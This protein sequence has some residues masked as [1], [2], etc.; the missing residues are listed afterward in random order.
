M[1]KGL[2]SF[3]RSA[4]NENKSISIGSLCEMAYSN[5]E[6]IMGFPND[7]RHRIRSSIYQMVKHGEIRK[8]SRSLYTKS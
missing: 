7:Y 5:R 1:E 8:L 6:H 2:T 3:I 4:F